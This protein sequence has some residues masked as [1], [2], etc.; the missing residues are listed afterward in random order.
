MT[1]NY[2]VNYLIQGLLDL[3]L[4]LATVIADGHQIKVIKCS[5][6]F[7]QRKR[8]VVKRKRQRNS[9]SCTDK[10]VALIT[11]ENQFGKHPKQSLSQGGIKGNSTSLNK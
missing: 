2:L 8:L 1:G 4:S 9:F 5:Y 7:S 10:S 11:L 3:W 6:Y